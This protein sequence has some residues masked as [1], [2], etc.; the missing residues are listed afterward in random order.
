MS[1]EGVFFRG[2]VNTEGRGEG[3]GEDVIMGDDTTETAGGDIFA[4]ELS[5]TSAPSSATGGEV[6]MLGGTTSSDEITSSS[7]RENSCS[8]AR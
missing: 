6:K 1:E 7:G 2:L 3:L 5:N 4:Q 8:S